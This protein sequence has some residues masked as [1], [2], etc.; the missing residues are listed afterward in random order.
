MKLNRKSEIVNRKSAARL[1]I[2]LLGPPHLERDGQ[3]ID[4][5]TRKG[6]ALLAYLAV[7]Q[8]RYRRDELAT[9]F[10]PESDQAQARAALR[11]ALWALN[12]GL[13]GDWLAADRETIGLNADADLWVDVVA[14]KDR[15]APC[16]SSQPPDQV[17]CATCLSLLTEAVS[18]YQGHFLSGFTL[19]DSPEF[20]AWQT[21]QTEHLRQSLSGALERLIACHHRQGQPEAAMTVARR[22]LDLDPLHEPAHRHL[23]QLYAAAGRRTDALRQ[24][25][26][27]R[28]ILADELG[29]SPSRETA[30]IYD[31]ILREDLQPADETPASTPAAPPRQ[32]PPLQAGSPLPA[33]RLA[34]PPSNLPLPPTNFVGRKEALAEIA[35]RLADPGC[36]L[37]TLIGPG[38]IGKTRLAIQAAGEALAANPPADSEAGHPFPDGVYF[39]RLS[40]L[41]NPEEAESALMDNIA[42]AVKFR[43]H[44]ARNVRTSPREQLLNYLRP[45]QLLLVLDNLEHYMTAAKFLATLLS[46]AQK[47]Q[48]LVTSR[49]RLNLQ[50]EWLY[51]VRGLG[52]PPPPPTATP[53]QH[54]PKPAAGDLLENYSAVKL[55]VQSAQRSTPSFTLTKDGRDDVVRICQ[56]VGGL[57]LAVELAAS[58][59]RLLS[60]P[61]IVNEIKH[62]LDF[63]TTTLRDLPQRHRNLRAVFEGSWQLLSPEEK[64]ALK[65]MAVFRRGFRREAAEAVTGASLIVFSALVDKS[66]LSVRQPDGAVQVPRYAMH[67]V[68][69]Q[70][71]AEKLTADELL[72]AQARHG[73]Y[74]ASF[75]QAREAAIRGDNQ[76]EIMAE[77]G[78]EIANVR[79]A[80][81]WAINH[82]PEPHLAAVDQSLDTLFHFFEIRSWFQEG[83]SA[84]RQAAERFQEA[85]PNPENESRTIRRVSGKL[86]ARQGGFA[87]RL[88]RHDLGQDLLQQS[89][90]LFGGLGPEAE[91]EVAIS[92]D[93]LGNIAFGLAGYPQ[94]KAYYRQS[95]TIKRKTDDPYGI[96]VTLS[97]LGHIAYLAGDF[98]EAQRYSA[99]SLAMGK[100][101]GNRWCMAFAMSNLGQVANARGDY[102]AA[103]RYYRQTLVE[104]EEIGER[105]L[106]AMTLNRLGSLAAELGKHAE[107]KEHLHQ[108]LTI[109]Q[110]IGDKRGAASAL[111]D[112]GKVAFYAEDYAEARTLLKQSLDLRR[113]IDDRHGEVICLDNLGYVAEALGDDQNAK[114][115][116]RDA[117]NIALEIQA[118]PLALDILVGLAILLLKET[119]PSQSQNQAQAVE[120]L[121][122]AL[123]HPASEQET[124]DQAQALLAE[125]SAPLSPLAE[126]GDLNAIAGKVMALPMMK[127]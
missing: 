64:T 80:W 82:R 14:F 17:D 16:M 110:E 47:V 94:A 76:T 75:L 119:G 104:C 55:F 113:E 109:H 114:A 43:F 52:Y 97:N 31:A 62:S 66:L 22:W 116:F 41:V 105:F 36:R 1:D 4:I 39:V 25:Q 2:F 23:M 35:A 122:L 60:L 84:F 127:E 49:E 71:A 11:S 59:V 68:I 92:L 118:D 53:A 12:K 61:E 8:L 10:W 100:R 103:G 18:L 38:G 20:D 101:L 37:L 89:L 45:K 73:Q 124:R 3:A 121:T 44:S 126:G 99:E 90:D 58:W 72:Q 70:Y 93:Q 86:L 32:A 7:T 34:P 21:S 78:A 54:L 6:I 50:G 91:A 88:S 69:R 115:Y 48:L 24:F 112:L 102:T 83:E 98:D 120:L 33:A 107:A 42:D 77:I 87:Y 27:C 65:L 96:S 15:L 95:L 111:N 19:R 106:M 28:Q 9:L 67:N 40:S 117:L 123:H 5:E 13:G 56:L 74:Y 125:L 63:L 30:A 29:V 26:D 81:R 46:T 79:A 51:E 57:P 108:S 85:W